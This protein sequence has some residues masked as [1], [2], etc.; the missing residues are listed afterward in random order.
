MGATVLGADWMNQHFAFVGAELHLS[1]S[2]LDVLHRVF[3]LLHDVLHA[4]VFVIEADMSKQRTLVSI[5]PLLG[6]TLLKFALILS[7]VSHN[8]RL[9]IN[10][11]CRLFEF[12]VF[13]FAVD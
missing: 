1:F 7:D 2:Y 8:E 4:L 12:N 3:E 9:H 13:L 5:Q 11:A 10:V 6:K